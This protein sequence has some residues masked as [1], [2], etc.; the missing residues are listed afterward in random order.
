MASLF[1]GKGRL[2]GGFLE[3]LPQRQL[4]VRCAPWKASFLSTRT[5]PGS[6]S[7]TE[8]LKL[9]GLLHHDLSPKE[10]AQQWLQL[11]G[12]RT[13]RN[14]A[15]SPGGLGEV[16]TSTRPG[17][18]HKQ[19]GGGRHLEGPSS[20]GPEHLPQSPRLFLPPLNGPHYAP[21]PARSEPEGCN[22]GSGSW[23]L[24]YRYEV[25]QIIRQ[26]KICSIP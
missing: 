17:S 3:Y 15:I 20:S 6:L 5:C 25:T 23:D 22:L 4:P 13:N 21:F 2:R 9:P 19:R 16:P 12:H 18:D 7:F 8:K 26:R 24:Y 1:F 14:Q 11:S 10:N